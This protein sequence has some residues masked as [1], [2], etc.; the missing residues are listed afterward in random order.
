MNTRSVSVGGVKYAIALNDE[1]SKRLARMPR[2]RTKP[3]ELVRRA[4]SRLGTRFSTKNRSLPGSPDFANRLEGWAIFVHGCFWHRHA[5]C[6]RA[7]TP[8][9]NRIFWLAKFA[10]NRRRDR[11]AIRALRERG[12]R[13]L[14][15][16]ECRCVDLL[17]LE[18]RVGRFL[19]GARRAES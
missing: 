14:V 18:R 10:D 11:R 4:L 19:K 8:I 16:W 6:R 13:T 1:T 7:T 9:R 2:E 12:F 15:V 3:E 17:Q 5:E